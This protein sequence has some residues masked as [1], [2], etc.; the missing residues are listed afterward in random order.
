[1]GWIAH[2]WH[3]T[4]FGCWILSRTCGRGWDEI[5]QEEEMNK[6]GPWKWLFGMLFASTR[7]DEYKL[8][9]GVKKR[10]DE[11]AEEEHHRWL[12]NYGLWTYFLEANIVSVGSGGKGRRQNSKK[13]FFRFL[14]FVRAHRSKSSRRFMIKWARRRLRTPFQGAKWMRRGKDPMGFCAPAPRRFC[15]LFIVIWFD[16]QSLRTDSSQKCRS[17]CWW[18]LQVLIPFHS[19]A[20]HIFPRTDHFFFS[21]LMFPGLANAFWYEKKGKNRE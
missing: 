12:R 3:T 21:V 4:S 5:S 19:F 18:T 9:C 7:W 8:V 2:Q 13:R 16:F 14:C 17:W 10:V 15:R 6:W 1:M 11:G 20:C